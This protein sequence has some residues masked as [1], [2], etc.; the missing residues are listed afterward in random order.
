MSLCMYM[1]PCTCLYVSMSPFFHVSCLHFSMSHVYVSMFPC[2]HL[3]VSIS[4]SPSPC[5]HL[6][7]SI[8]MSSCL[9]VHVSMSMSPCPCFHVSRILQ[10]ENGTNRKRG[11]PFVCCKGKTETAN[12]RLFAADGNG[13]RKF[14]FPWSAKLSNN[15]RLLFLQTCPSMEFQCIYNIKCL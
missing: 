8:A 3:H 15:R 12:L 13:K 6:H 10:T 7:V 9:Y 14:F 11:L 5:L 2:L 4:M 1:S